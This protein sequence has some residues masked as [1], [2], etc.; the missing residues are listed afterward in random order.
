M[1][2]QGIVNLNGNTK[3]DEFANN[4]YDARIADVRDIFLKGQAKNRDTPAWPIKL[5]ELFQARL[6]HAFADLII[7]PASGKDN[8]RMI[9]GF[10]GPMCQIIGI[11]PDTVTTD[12][13][14]PEIKKIP[15]G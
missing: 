15:F 6:G 8:L 10:F 2:R 11:D 13:S 3:T 7:D 9:T 4:V 14:G 5:Q 1:I 12:K